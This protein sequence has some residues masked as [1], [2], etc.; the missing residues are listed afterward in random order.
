LDFVQLH[1]VLRHLRWAKLL[2]VLHLKLRD[3]FNPTWTWNSR[4]H[5]LVDTVYDVFVNTYQAV[6]MIRA[7]REI[8]EVFDGL[9]LKTNHAFLA[10]YRLRFCFYGYVVNNQQIQSC[11][12]PL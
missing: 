9:I 5:S 12:I 6:A 2:N 1:I 8:E 4:D 7:L 3:T 11:L 10:G